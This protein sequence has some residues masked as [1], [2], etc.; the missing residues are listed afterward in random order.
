MKKILII[1]DD[2]E[3]CEVVRDAF[4]KFKGIE[5]SFELSP[6]KAIKTLNNSRFD[7]LILDYK[8]PEIDGFEFLDRTINKIL[9]ESIK[10]I[11]MTAYGNLKMGKDA[12][13][14]GCFDYI[15]KPFNIEDLI[16]RV[17]RA[18]EVEKTPDDKEIPYHDKNFVTGK[19]NEIKKIYKTIQKVA[20]QDITV[21]FEGETGTGKEVVARMLHDF[22]NRKNEL[23]IPVNCGSF[24][25][26]VIESELFGHEKGAFTNADSKKIG[27]FEIADNGTLF[28]DEINS[29]AL[30]VQAKLLRLIESGEFFRLG[31]NMV[32]KCNTR[33]LAATNQD[34]ENLVK[35]GKF[36]EDLYY[37]LNI[38]KIAI[39]P[40][41]N[42]KDDIPLLVNYFLDFYNK[43]FNKKLLID[44]EVLDYFI[45]YD[46]PGN[47]RELKNLMHSLVLLSDSGSI[48]EKDL[49]ERLIGDKYKSQSFKELKKNNTVKFE[50]AYF[51]KILEKTN[52]NITKAAKLAKMNRIFLIDKLKSL[53][54]DPELFRIKNKN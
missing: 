5:T 52:G 44:P 14:R 53:G 9:Q 48:H 3:I 23:F 1:D 54:I 38:V 7:L 4:L 47:I 8:L 2:K 32:L 36:R 17:H 6:V 25:E 35:K 45:K 46:W 34:I 28:L 20:N 16:F 41:K 33:V 37:R 42:R 40:L 15:S 13:R 19:S 27:L 51:K 18:L 29:M 12:I 21:L 26:E 39:P 49:P 11:M 50:I 10:V 43:K 30:K 24:N 22:S 31:G